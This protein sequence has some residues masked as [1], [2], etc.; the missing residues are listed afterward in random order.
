MALV[1]REGKNNNARIGRLCRRVRVCG[2]HVA[3]KNKC[4]NTQDGEGDGKGKGP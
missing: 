2:K 4:E 1:K 3:D